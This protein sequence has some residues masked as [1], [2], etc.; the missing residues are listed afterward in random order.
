M[1][2][3][4]IIRRC[5]QLFFL[6]LFIYVLWSTTYPLKGIFS[7]TL[8]FNVDPLVMVVASLSA[9]VLLAG[10][11]LAILTVIATLIFGRFFCGWICPLGTVIDMAGA[12]RKRHRTLSDRANRYARRIKFYILGGIFFAAAAGIQIV[13]IFDPL[14]IMGRFVSLN[15]IPA[16]TAGIDRIFIFFIR[17]FDWYGPVYD[18]YRTLKA[19]LLG[20]QVHFFKHSIISFLVLV[21]LAGSAFF[22]TRAWCRVMCPLGALL[23]LFARLTPF[24]RRTEGCMGCDQCQEVCRMGAIQT[25]HNYHAGECILCMDCVYVCPPRKTRFSFLARHRHQ[26]KIKD[27]NRKGLSRKNFIF[28][29][30]T[31]LFSFGFL[32]NKKKAFVRA[33]IRPPGSLREDQFLDTCIRCGN[34]MKVCVT[35]GLQPVMLETGA[36]GIWTPR[37][38]PEIGYCEYLCTLCTEVCP[39]GAIPRLSKTKKVTTR[40]GV[41]QIDHSLCIAWANNQQCLVCEEHCPIPEKAIKVETAVRDGKT[42][43]LPI[44]DPSLC[45]GCGICQNKCPVRPVRAIRVNPLVA[46]RP[47]LPDKRGT[48]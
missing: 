15:M 31:S 5:S 3:L 37:L 23:N 20:V 43:L 12:L 47:D 6:A 1:K 39:T 45:V 46:D 48:V 44:V 36:Q 40:L 27:E 24:R 11:F 9:R 21:V 34:C 35:N 30:L 41:A 19:S 13:W 17:T 16:V 28:L 38:V 29:L 14:V 10:S 7:P 8:L 22:L 42:V 25:D 32:K 2:K 4:I 33:I 18:F 26:P